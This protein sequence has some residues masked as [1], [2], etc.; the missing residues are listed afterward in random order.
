MSSRW[1]GGKTGSSKSRVK[2]EL[3]SSVVGLPTFFPAK[4]APSPARADMPAPCQHMCARTPFDKMHALWSSWVVE[5]I[6]KA[7]ETDVNVSGVSCGWSI[8][9]DVYLTD[10]HSSVATLAIRRLTRTTMISMK[11]CPFVLLSRRSA[12]STALSIS[13][14]CLLAPTRPGHSCRRCILRL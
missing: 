13:P 8:L 6:D 12:T 2:G 14:Y 3:E 11:A 4:N 10:R 1:T 9:D 7:G 5:S